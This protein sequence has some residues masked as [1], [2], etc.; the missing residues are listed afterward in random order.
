MLVRTKFDGYVIDGRRLYLGSKGGSSAPAP[1][2]RLVEAQ[3]K[4]MGIQDDAIQRIMANAEALQP[5]QRE[6]MQFGIDSA[7]TAFEQSQDDRAYALARR[8]VLSGLQDRL[9]EDAKSFDTEA[10]REELAGQAGAD[11]RQA[12]GAARGTAARDMARM[13][14]NPASGRFA[15]SMGQL[16]TQEALAEAGAKTTARRAARQEG[17]AMTDRATNALAGYP[18]M[19]MQATGAGAQFAASGINLANTGLA[20]MNSGFGSAAQVAGQMG[21]NASGMYGQQA[22]YK[23]AQDRLALEDGGVMGFLGTVAGSGITKYSDRR[24]KKNVREIGRD[25]RGFGW[26]EFDYVWGGER[27]VGVMADEVVRV[28]PDAVGES[29]GYATVNYAML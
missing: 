8:G 10:R 3:I 17:V 19:G 9:A 11:V 22:S 13:G 4:S 28:A 26:Y 21:A 16:S 5:L 2:P 18:A 20:G 24:L 12:F 15:A 27:Q 14:V 6:Q 29:G 1:D 25:P 23:N 7:R